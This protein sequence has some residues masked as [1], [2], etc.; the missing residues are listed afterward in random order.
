MDNSH[1][2]PT[3]AREGVWILTENLLACI[4]FLPLPLHPPFT[5]ESILIDFSLVFCFSASLHH[6]HP[7]SQMSLPGCWSPPAASLHSRFLPDKTPPPLLPPL[8]PFWLVLQ[9][10]PAPP[11]L[12]DAVLQP[13]SPALHDFS[14]EHFDSL[15]YKTPCGTGR[16][17]KWPRN[18]T[19]TAQSHNMNTKDTAQMQ[20]NFKWTIFISHD[21]T[22][23]THSTVPLIGSCSFPLWVG[24]VKF[25]NEEVKVRSYSN[26]WASLVVFWFVIYNAMLFYI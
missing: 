21:G 20:Q 8:P 12:S 26:W 10:P 5:H 17:I 23:M 22:R 14:C 6:R 9:L 7:L 24:L 19:P 18:I 16:K 3:L 15:L 13:S 1:K 25:R 4:F 11:P 2:E